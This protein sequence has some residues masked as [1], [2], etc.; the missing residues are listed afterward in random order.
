[1]LTPATSAIIE[2]TH[3]ALKLVKTDLRSTMAEGGLN[4]LMLL[5]VHQNIPLDSES[6]ITAFAIRI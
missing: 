5:Y 3:S 1:M 4:A 2:R 6:I